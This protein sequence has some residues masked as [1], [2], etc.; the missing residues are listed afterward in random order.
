MRLRVSGRMQRKNLRV[1]KRLLGTW[2]SDRGKTFRHFVPWAG[3]KGRR[4]DRFKAIFGKLK[5]TYDR[6]KIRHELGEYEHSSPYKVLA[7]DADSVAILTEDL[8]TGGQKIWHI[9]FDGDYYWI[10]FGHKRQVTEYFRRIK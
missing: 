9:H 4:L 7:R 2:K 3:L 6:K 1:D 5:L 8:V 10:A